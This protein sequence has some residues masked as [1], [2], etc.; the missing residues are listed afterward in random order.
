MTSY[1][2]IAVRF[3]TVNILDFLARRYGLH[4]NKCYSL[5][6]FYKLAHLQALNPNEFSISI[7]NFKL[8]GEFDLPIL[9][10]VKT[11]FTSVKF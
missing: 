11:T 5:Q 1:F 6:V 10:G 4:L 9:H 7:K 8:K 2:V 3:L